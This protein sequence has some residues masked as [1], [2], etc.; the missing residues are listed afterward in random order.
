MPLL[1]YFA[2]ASFLLLSK[3]ISFNFLKICLAFLFLWMAF[4]TKIVALPWLALPFFIKIFSTNHAITLFSISWCKLIYAF[5]GSGCLLFLFFGLLFG[6]EDIFFH[7]FQSTN[8]YS[9]RECLSLWGGSNEHLISNDFSS[10][11]NALFRLSILYANEYWILLMANCFIL[12]HQ[13]RLKDNILLAWL[14]VSY[15]LFC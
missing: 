2:V 8:S 5:S 14:S 6:F 9:F 10:K 15:F 7:L 11:I 3:S 1:A 13:L 12:L 4:W